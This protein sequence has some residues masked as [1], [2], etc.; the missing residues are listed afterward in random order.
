LYGFW[1]SEAS[2]LSAQAHDAIKML[3]I[4]NPHIRAASGKE[5]KSKKKKAGLL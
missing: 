5:K 4:T 1:L 2:L 3:F